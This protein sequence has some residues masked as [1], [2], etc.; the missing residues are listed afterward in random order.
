MAGAILTLILGVALSGVAWKRGRRKSA[1]GVAFACAGLVGVLAYM[2]MDS[3]PVAPPI[4]T[5]EFPPKPSLKSTAACAAGETLV[6]G[7][8]MDAD[9]IKATTMLRKAGFIARATHSTR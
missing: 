6:H 9:A 3:P 5:S 7:E 2:T 8:C 4:P 1:G